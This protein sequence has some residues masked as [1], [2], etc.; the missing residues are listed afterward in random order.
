MIVVGGPVWMYISTG[1]SCFRFITAG[2]QTARP[3]TQQ[4]T[5]SGA[6]GGCALQHVADAQVGQYVEGGGDDRYVC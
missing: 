3:I 1:L 2:L 6:H 4:K 5:A